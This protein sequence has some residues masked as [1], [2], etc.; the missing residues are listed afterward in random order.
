MHLQG[1]RC[2]RRGWQSYFWRP[3]VSLAAP[4]SSPAGT[5]SPKQPAAL[6][7]PGQPHR[8]LRLAFSPGPGPA[9]LAKHEPAALLQPPQ[10]GS[11]WLASHLPAKFQ[12]REVKAWINSLTLNDRK[13]RSCRNGLKQVE[14]WL[15]AQTDD[16]F[17]SK[18]RRAAVT[19]TKLQKQ[20]L[21]RLIAAASF[22]E[23]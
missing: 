9:N 16:G 12:E 6:A 8:Q 21:G 1:C 7:T 5:P 14:A 2:R 19:V 11:N 3:S 18:I 22:V 10:K 23:R 15:D 17:I 20:P 4:G 13:K